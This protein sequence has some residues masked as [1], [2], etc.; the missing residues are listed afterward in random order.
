MWGV[1]VSLCLALLKLG[2]Q[3]GHREMRLGY[4]QG[5]GELKSEKLTQA[6]L[7]RNW[8]GCPS[9]QRRAKKFGL[10]T[11]GNCIRDAPLSPEQPVSRIK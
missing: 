2:G 10:T 4:F 5:G 11:I 3:L 7:Q 6:C 1:D 9:F 8:R